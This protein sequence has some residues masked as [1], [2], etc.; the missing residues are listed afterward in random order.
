MRVST[1]M[2]NYL[3]KLVESITTCNATIRN[4]WNLY[5]R[6]RGGRIRESL[7]FRS[8]NLSKL[9]T[10]PRANFFLITRHFLTSHASF[11]ILPRWNQK[12]RSSKI[13]RARRTLKFHANSQTLGNVSRVCEISNATKMFRKLYILNRPSFPTRIYQREEETEDFFFFFFCRRKKIIPTDT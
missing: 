2:V 7:G 5:R 12:L 13:S 4:T 1:D 11:H 10:L 3:I 6:V 9:E 8:W